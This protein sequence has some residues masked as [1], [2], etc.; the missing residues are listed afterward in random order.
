MHV[1][2]D[3]ARDLTLRADTLSSNAGQF[4]QPDAEEYAGVDFPDVTRA[5]SGVTGGAVGASIA[6]KP[7]LRPNVEDFAN[8]AVM[9]FGEM[10]EANGGQ[11][12]VDEYLAGNLQNMLAH[13]EKMEAGQTLES[14]L[15]RVAIGQ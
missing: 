15:A 1:P 5:L 14:N 3:T 12:E 4:Q 13:Y 8:S 6:E 2:L 11:L 10:V 7:H 9:A